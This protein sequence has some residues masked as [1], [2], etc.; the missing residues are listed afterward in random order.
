MGP[1]RAERRDPGQHEGD[2]PP[3]L[4]KRRARRP[5]SH[6]RPDTRH[7]SARCCRI[8]RRPRPLPRRAHPGLPVRRTAR[9]RQPHL[10]RRPGRDGRR[11]RGVH[12]GCPARS[13]AA[14]GAGDRAVH[15]HRSIDRA[16]GRAWRS[17]LAVAA[18]RPPPGCPWAA[19]AVRRGT[20]S[21]SLATASSRK[22]SMALPERSA[23]RSRSA[24][25]SGSSGSRS[26]PGSTSARSRSYPTTSRDL[27]S[28]SEPASRRSPARARCSCR[29]P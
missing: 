2:R 6:P 12:H 15:G 13:G 29:V 10:G 26:G 20:R 22:K 4:R 1:V 27:P 23:V 25:R 28:T 21:R 8:S 16:G 9:H 7:P 19:Q 5:T 24:T 18:G 3:D 14:S 17:T 11:D